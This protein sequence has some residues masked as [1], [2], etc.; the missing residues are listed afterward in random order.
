MIRDSYLHVVDVKAYPDVAD[1]RRRLVNVPDTTAYLG[2]WISPEPNRTELHV[3]S[4]E[5]TVRDLKR[6]GW[7][8]V[9]PPKEDT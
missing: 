2:R 9:Q 7:D 8:Q 5:A 1:A 6:A 4:D 3:F